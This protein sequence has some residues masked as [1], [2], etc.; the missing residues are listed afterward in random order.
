MYMI[1]VY[2]YIH[3][4]GIPSSLKGDVTN[5]ALFD[6]YTIQFLLA[7]LN[8]NFLGVR[9]TNLSNLSIGGA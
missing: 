7:K 3:I 1:C 2:I 4:G 8:P 9:T 5:P 6:S